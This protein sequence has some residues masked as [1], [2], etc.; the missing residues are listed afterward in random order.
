M[1]TTVR[2]ETM[3]TTKAFS[4]E[5]ISRHNSPHDAWVVV[6]GRVCDLTGFVR[7]HPGGLD[8]LEE[9][10]GKDV[11]RV[12]RSP[13][14]HRHSRAAFEILDQ[15][16]IGVLQ[17]ASRKPRVSLVWFIAWPLWNTM[18]DARLS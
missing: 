15:C 3:S 17:G 12:L 13:S 16:C 5:D 6:D 2:S 10:L 4:K 11:S 9:H 8:V 7:G 14:F 18:S 1:S